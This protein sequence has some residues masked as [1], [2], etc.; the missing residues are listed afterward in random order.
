MT[1]DLVL[2]GAGA[3]GATLGRGLVAAGWT[4]REV[5]CR[6]RERAVARCALVGAG[7]PSDVAALVA[8]SREPGRGPALLLVAVSDDALA[9]V[10]RALSAGRWAAGSVA[11]HL[12]GALEVDA[13]APLRAAGVAIG[14]LHPLAS[15][16]DP[17]RDVTR[18]RGAAC[19][20]DGDD[21]ARLLGERVASDLGAR[22]LWLRPGTRSAWHAGATHAANHLVALVDQALDLIE[23]AGVARDDGRAAL[24]PLLR[25][26]LEHLADRAPSAALT[27]PVRRGDADTLAR[28]SEAL[29]DA[30]SDVGRTYALLAARALL[31]ARGAGLDEAA[32]RRVDHALATLRS[33]LP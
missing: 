29:A 31:L 5:V 11:L 14:A 22:P 27:G 13:L 21:A 26:V 30:P 4:V 7:I 3:A 25:G 1:H 23:A 9:E 32:A 2:V 24:L 8:A 19:A 17:A 20:L 16:V 33:T 28:H 18:L 12:S 15:L 10:A 6:T